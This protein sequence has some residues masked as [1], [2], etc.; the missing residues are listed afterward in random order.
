[1][2]AV[3]PFRLIQTLSDLQRLC[4]ELSSQRVLGVDTEADSLYHYFPKV[5][6]IQISTAQD[7]FVIDPLS[8]QTMDPLHPIFAN[9]TIKKVFHG[10]DY[11]VRSLFRCL[12]MKVNN[13]FDTMVASQFLGEKETALAAVVQRRFGVTLDKKYQ[14]SNWSKRPLNHDMILYAAHDSAY[15]IRLYGELEK[16]LRSKGRLGWVEEECQILSRDAVVNDNPGPRDASRAKSLNGHV[17]G[18]ANKAVPS[19]F[20][21]FK[22]AGKLVGRDLAVLEEILQFR[23]K[24]AMEKDKP[25]FRIFPN[26][27]IQR[28]VKARPTHRAALKKMGDL[29]AD[30]MKR[31]ADGVLDAIQRALALPGS[32]LP[33]FPKTP[34]PP[35]DRKKEARLK[36]LKTWRGRKAKDL[37]L[38]P[39]LMCNNHLL[40]A[41]AEHGPRHVDDL[42]AIEKMR[43][44]QRTAFGKEIV[45]LL[46]RPHT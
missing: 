36:L 23:E 20:R 28:L 7:T 33:S 31:Y 37:E 22:G 34:R 1:L 14:R 44:W 6:L 43:V 2:P 26:P 5:C 45:Q 24:I 18:G 25:P 3:S 4:R 35:R 38:E 8:I 12:R 42:K 46:K 16:A 15:L 11:D 41:F 13:L 9:P 19:L 40:H 17:T 27:V 29:P 32:S 21:R 39:G 10:A 30:F